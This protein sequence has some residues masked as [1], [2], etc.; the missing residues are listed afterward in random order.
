MWA[1][2]SIR[3]NPRLECSSGFQQPLPQ[4]KRD[5]PVL[6]QAGLQD[7]LWRRDVARMLAFMLAGARLI[8]SAA[9]R[10]GF[11]CGFR[12]LKPH[13]RNDQQQHQG[14]KRQGTQRRKVLRIGDHDVTF[15]TVSY[16]AECGVSW[17]WVAPEGARCGR[18]STT[19]DI[20][21]CPQ[22]LHSNN[23]P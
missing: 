20:S 3:N 13:R 10:L 16:P 22:K 19:A 14:K 12:C 17:F 15:R 23:S 2:T 11:G 4:L 6:A 9:R 18:P 1:I 8:T 7:V 5:Q 21:T